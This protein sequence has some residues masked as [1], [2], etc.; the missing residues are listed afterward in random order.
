MTKQMMIALAGMIQQA[1][2]EGCLGVNSEG[3]KIQLTEEKFREFFSEWNVRKQDEYDRWYEIEG[4]FEFF[5][6]VKH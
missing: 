1:W 2:E 6:L 3:K 4:G 5:T